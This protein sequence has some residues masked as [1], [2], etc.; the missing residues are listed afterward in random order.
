M[1]M[2]PR[3]LRTLGLVAG[4]AVIGSGLVAGRCYPERGGTLV[5]QGLPGQV[6]PGQVLTLTIGDSTFPN[7]YCPSSVT[8][9]WTWS[10]SRGQETASRSTIAWSDPRRRSGVNCRGALAQTGPVRTIQVTVPPDYAGGRLFVQMD[11]WAK[12]GDVYDSYQQYDYYAVGLA[13]R[14]APVARLV[15]DAAPMGFRQGTTVDARGSVDPMGQSLQYAWDLDADG[16]YDDNPGTTTPGTA[17]ITSSMLWGRSAAAGRPAT[18]APTEDLLQGVDRMQRCSVTTDAFVSLEAAPEIT[19]TIPVQAGLLRLWDMGVAW[20]DVNPAAGVFT[21]SVLDQRIAQAKASGARVLLVLGL[22]PQWAAADPNAG[23]PRWG[24]GSASPPRDIADWQRYVAAVADRYGSSIA[25]YEVWNEANLRTFWVG[26]GSQMAD[27][28][29]AAYREIKVRVPGATVL[30][31]SVTTRLRGPMGLFMSAFLDGAAAGNYPFDGFAIHTY[32]AGNAGPEQRVLDITNWQAVVSGKLGPNSSVLDRPVW[33]TEVNYGLAGPSP[34]PGT[35]YTDAQGAELMA[36]T[37]MDSQRLGIDATFWYMYTA[38]PY[39][40]LGVQFWSGTPLTV[41]A[42]N[43][44]R[45]RFAAGT[46]RCRGK[47]SVGVKVTAAD[48]RSS[49]TRSDFAYTPDITE[50]GVATTGSIS[51]VQTTYGVGQP[52]SLW[53]AFPRQA[54]GQAG[55]STACVDTFGTGSYTVPV[56][57]QTGQSI[58]GTTIPGRPSPGL[59]SYSIAYWQQGANPSCGNTSAAGSGLVQVVSGFYTVGSRARATS[60]R[61]YQAN[62]RLRLGTGTVVVDG[63]MDATGTLSGTVVR[64]AYT[65]R[66]PARAGGVRRPAPLS[67]FTKGAYAM[68][69]GGVAASV[70]PDGT[71]T[72]VGPFTVLLRGRGGALICLAGDGT[73]EQSTLTSTGG[74]RSATRLSFAAID[75]PGAFTAAAN[76]EVPRTTSATAVISASTVRHTQA[77]PAGCRSLVRYLR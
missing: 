23:D 16:A 30:A 27:L 13:G 38:S 43:D 73:L 15:A 52:I 49:T 44:A 11:S 55:V 32:P 58:Y 12:P 18:A 48:G 1:R 69:T 9:Y 21:W 24:A 31:P 36:Q 59:Y 71:R 3:M 60:T 19:S 70:T 65:M 53:L 20:R 51:A 39:S 42:W 67:L 64:G 41:G 22:T 4:L 63:S 33:D 7:G 66:T 2:P 17:R 61:V 34:T 14:G 40:L 26:S 54:S 46:D 37:F 76:G 8:Y 77:L 50:N 57:Y 72:Y 6:T 28:T 47:F 25:A 29:A 56:T 5:L 10:D 68:R 75:D 74:T 45:S 62:A 35:A